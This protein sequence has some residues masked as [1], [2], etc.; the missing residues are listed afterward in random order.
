MVSI[1][2]LG[3]ISACSDSDPTSENQRTNA[4][5]PN[6][7]SSSEFSTMSD[8]SPQESNHIIVRGNA[9]LEVEPDVATINLSIESREST[10]VVARENTASAM[11]TLIKKLSET[12][13]GDNSV[14]TKS[15][16][17]TPITQWVTVKDDTGEYGEQRILGYTVVNSVSIDL[18][19][20]DRV[21]EIIDLAAVT[22]R[23]LI[24]IGSIGF[25]VKD[26][27]HYSNQLRMLAVENALEKAK[28]YAT[29]AQ[30]ELGN[31]ISLEEIYSPSITTM[32]SPNYKMMA[33]F[34]TPINPAEM[35]LSVNI[36][37]TYEINQKK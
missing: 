36:I 20:I 3:L 5:L 27:E 10:V 30:V 7:L 24:R 35:K 11:L 26:P 13:I 19:D 2:L 16:S 4:N 6:A 1:L 23:D 8:V 9:V 28:S 31:L 22:G 32:E 34:N 21:G 29:A 18:D 12:G 17:I 25:N 14:H 33:E 15:F 37:A